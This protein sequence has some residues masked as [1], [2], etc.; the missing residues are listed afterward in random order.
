M[1]EFQYDREKKNCCLTTR[2]IFKRIERYLVIDS[3]LSA[4]LPTIILAVV[5]TFKKIEVRISREM[6]NIIYGI[7][8]SVEKIH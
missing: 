4:G 8:W 2:G 6:G 3:Y 1:Y 7:E 5:K